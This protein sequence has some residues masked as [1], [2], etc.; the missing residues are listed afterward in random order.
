MTA[1]ILAT[2]CALNF[3]AFAAD[4]DMEVSTSPAPASVGKT[5][6]RSKISA[7]AEA[8]P[9]MMR[10]TY[11]GADV[12]RVIEDYAKA[13]G[14]KFIVDGQVKGKIS[15][16]NPGPI[17]IEEAF[18]QLSTALASNRIGISTRDDQMYVNE[19]RAIQRDLIPVV[20]E[21]PTVRPDR[22]VTLV[23][24]LKNV[25]ADE[26]NKQLRIMTSRDGELVPYTP[27][28]QLLISDWTPN[29]RRIADIVKQIDVPAENP[30]QPPA[31]LAEPP[32][33]APAEAPEVPTL[34]RLKPA[35]RPKAPPKPAR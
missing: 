32:P 21:V 34:P 2:L 22:M 20:T 6:A 16:F 13:S 19:A 8:K 10:F 5:A 7:K 14:Q 24:N 15:I 23:I 33:E 35:P 31:A 17:T 27:N 3:A 25:S 1:L 4:D 11:K 29:L 12:N 9:A 28:N 26:V 18:N 30:G